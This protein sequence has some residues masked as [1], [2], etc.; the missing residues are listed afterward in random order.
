MAGEQELSPERFGAA[1]KGFMEAVLREASP[2]GGPLLERLRAHLGADLAKLPVT[3]EEFDPHDHPN[4]QVAVEDVLGREGRRS[5]LVGVG[6][7]TSGTCTSA[8]RIC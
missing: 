3:V 8:S 6:R 2:G 4:V 1:F 5:E 7:S